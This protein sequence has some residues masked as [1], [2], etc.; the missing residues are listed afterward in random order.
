MSKENEYDVVV[1]GAGSGGLTSAVGLSKVGKRV[2]LVERE[3]MGGECTNTGWVPSKALLHH[4]KEYWRATRIAGR[5]TASE[6]Y[7]NEAFS[8]V[9]NTIN[10][11]LAEETPEHF[12]KM[13]ISVVMGEAIFNDKCSISV[14]GTIYKYKTAIIATGSSPKTINIPG[15][16]SGLI[17]TNQNIFD[18]HNI[19]AKLLIIGGGPIGM[20][21]GQALA[22]LGSEV[23]IV[24]N[25]NR[26]AR[27]EDI[28]I[29]PI[30]ENK[31]RY[32]NTNYGSWRL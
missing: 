17:L 13:G 20:E 11:I 24:D 21:L 29:S 30:I 7:R 25:G 26:F 32:S 1:I 3:H 6:T 8:H 12:Q 10:N 28:A 23:T 31:F 18:L 14:G 4:A 9:R 22:M 27:L 16:D 5:S 2:L 15:L 19:P